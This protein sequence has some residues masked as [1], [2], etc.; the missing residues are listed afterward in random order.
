MNDKLKDNEQ[1][2]QPVVGKKAYTPPAL[3]LYGKL[4]ELTTG[5]MGSKVESN[6][7]QLQKRP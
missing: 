3:I 5:G 7:N 4:T 2:E 1:Q 6:T